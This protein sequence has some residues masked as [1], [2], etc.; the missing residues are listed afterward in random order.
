MPFIVRAREAAGRFW[1]FPSVRSDPSDS[2]QLAC[3]VFGRPFGPWR[4]GTRS[5]D[6]EKKWQPCYFG[7]WAVIS[8]PHE[9]HWSV[10]RH[11]STRGDR[12]A[13]HLVAYRRRGGR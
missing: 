6:D 3:P 4:R 2:I 10:V 1:V 8:C 7:R 12:A 5:F 11:P 9:A 13:L